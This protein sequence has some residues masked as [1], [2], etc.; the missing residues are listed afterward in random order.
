MSRFRK[1]S[2]IF[3][4]SH[5]MEHLIVN[6][7]LTDR[8]RFPKLTIVENNAEQEKNVFQVFRIHG[9]AMDFVKRKSFKGRQRYGHK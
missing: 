6:E 8:R 9:L 3:D 4:R 5:R 1:C 7:K 2:R